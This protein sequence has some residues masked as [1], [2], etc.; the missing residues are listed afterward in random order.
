[1]KKRKT[2][3]SSLSTHSIT[4]KSFLDTSTVY[5]LGVGT[6]VH[7]EYLSRTIPE[8]WYVNN[9][10]QMEYYRTCLMH[11][12]QL[13]FESEDAIHQTFGD[14]LKFYA[15]GFGREA[16]AAVNVIASMET[17]GLSFSLPKDKEFCRQALQDTILIMAIQFR[18]T[19][20]NM[21]QDPTHCARVPHPLRLSDHVDRDGLLLRV[22]HDFKAEKECRGRCTIHRLFENEPYKTKMEVIS[23]LLPTGRSKHALERIQEAITT[24]QKLPSEIT[25][26]SCGKMGDAVIATSLDKLWK[27]HSM[28]EVHGLISVALGLEHQIHLSA[29]ALKKQNDSATSA[30]E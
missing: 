28:D 12:I 22:F 23:K 15:E 24:A 18:D 13:Y 3:R 30:A 2:T 29:K 7:Q 19:Y 10:V 1:M 20:I 6:T 21:G 8:E 4:A 26:R 5:K 17:G 9:Y 16:K 14:A 11:W 25:C 27:L